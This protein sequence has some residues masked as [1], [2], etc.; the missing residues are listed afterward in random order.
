MWA[1][2]PTGSKSAGGRSHQTLHQ[3]V[4]VALLSHCWVKNWRAQTRGFLAQPCHED[5]DSSPPKMKIAPSAEL[6]ESY[7]IKTAQALF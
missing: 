1:C 7:F 5:A 3:K 4:Y 6:V 2:T